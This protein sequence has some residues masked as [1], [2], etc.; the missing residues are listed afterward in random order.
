MQLTGYTIF[1]L[2][3][4]LVICISLLKIALHANGWMDAGGGGGVIDSVSDIELDWTR[5]TNYPRPRH[6]SYM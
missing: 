3:L 5:L 1:D 4:L 2:A 6:P